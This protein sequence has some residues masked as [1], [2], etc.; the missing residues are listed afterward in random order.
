MIERG[1]VEDDDRLSGWL[2]GTLDATNAAELA[3]ACTS[4]PHWARA[5]DELVEV[6][7][8][9]RALEFAEP[10]PGFLESLVAA[11]GDV[12]STHA[13]SP[14]PVDIEVARARRPRRA[15]SGVA[16]FAAVAAAV[17]VAFVVPSLGHAKPALA[18]DIRVHQAGVAS[19]GDPISGLAP[20]GT[21]MKFG[22]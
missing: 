22:R 15:S 11:R 8:V 5:L 21:G 20:L 9:M 10:P 14:R 17:A 19:S 6:R 2:D 7:T 13:G 18:T 3:A 1:D 12:E 16:A 4:D